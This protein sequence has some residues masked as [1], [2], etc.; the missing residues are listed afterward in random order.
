MENIGRLY[1]GECLSNGGISGLRGGFY[2][3][4]LFGFCCRELQECVCKLMI[5]S[6][7]VD[8]ERLSGAKPS[9]NG[10]QITHGDI[11]L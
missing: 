1:K 9:I 4:V 2:F 3:V 10:I 6:V 8:R 7:P 11:D 5:I